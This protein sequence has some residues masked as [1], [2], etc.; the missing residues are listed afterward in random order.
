MK[1]FDGVRRSIIFESIDSILT[2]AE[3]QIENLRS[4]QIH[5][6]AK[7]VEPET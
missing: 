3:N 1:N 6:E 5:G 7:R 4:V 2:H